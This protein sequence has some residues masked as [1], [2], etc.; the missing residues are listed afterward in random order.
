MYNIS[1]IICP[2]QCP[3]CGVEQVNVYRCPSSTNIE[4]RVHIVSEMT[5]TVSSGTLNSTIP[6][7]TIPYQSTQLEVALAYKSNYS[8]MPYHPQSNW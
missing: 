5:Y 2:A 1:S 8:E 6:Y 7:R 4:H 3:H